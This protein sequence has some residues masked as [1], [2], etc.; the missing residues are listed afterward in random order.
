VEYWSAAAV[1]VS[2]GDDRLTAHA[3]LLRAAVAEDRVARMG[4]E[5]RSACEGVP[6][7]S[8]WRALGCLLVGVAWHLTGER[9]HARTTLEEGA[10]RGAARAPNIQAL[11]LAQLALLAIERRDWAAAESLAARAKAQVVRSGLG[12]YPTSA[13][14]YAVSSDVEARLGRV[15]ASQAD[16]EQAIGLLGALTDFSP[17]YE[18]EC[19]IALAR[20]AVRLSDSRQASALLADAAQQLQRAPDA[21]VAFG[22]IEDCKEQAEL[23]SASSAGAD[24]S[25]TTAELR[26]LQFLPT[27]LSFPDIA[28]RLYVSANT[29]KT[30][31]RSV[32][33]KL[34]ASSRGEAV[35]QAREAGLL[36]QAAHAGLPGVS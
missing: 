24:W 17:W 23:C 18:A 30:H 11:C 10:R 2:G 29:V 8:P 3:A 1:R 5:A 7:D 34:G 13:L 33:R 27:H 16:A 21:E 20:A 12:A 36:D 22:W 9:K 14:V 25:L 32:Y 19:R 6:D 15:E 31:A 26:V 35:G 28:E 4:E